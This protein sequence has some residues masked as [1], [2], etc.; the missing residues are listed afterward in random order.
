MERRTTCRRRRSLVVAVVVALGAARAHAQTLLDA[1]PPRLTSAAPPFAVTA[2]P[3]KGMAWVAARDIAVGENVIQEAAV[4]SLR[5]GFREDEG[6][7]A[8]AALPVAQRTLVEALH[9]CRAPSSSLSSKT[10]VGIFQTNALPVGLQSNRGGLFPRI[11]RINHA[12]LPNLNF[13]YN[14]DLAA[15]EMYAVK[16]ITRGEEMTFSYTG[17]PLETRAQRQTYLRHAFAFDCGCPCCALSP[18]KSARSD[19]RR[20]RLRTLTADVKAAI[21]RAQNEGPGAVLPGPAMNMGHMHE[22]LTLLHEEGLDNAMQ[23]LLC[24]HD[25]YQLLAATGRDDEAR[26]WLEQAAAC[27]A[28]AQGPS[29]KTTRRLRQLLA[30]P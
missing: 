6:V 25:A 17:S 14:E 24:Y 5:R 13:Y 7:A 26:G 28:Q 29:S 19:S 9:D 23:L 18:E 20:E 21:R 11:A 1:P 27:A 3:G 30:S 16:P 22:R 8:V 15:A 12:C 2:L 10:V 4:L